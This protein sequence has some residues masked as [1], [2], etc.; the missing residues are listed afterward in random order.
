MTQDNFPFRLAFRRTNS[1]GLLEALAGIPPALG[2]VGDVVIAA[3][4]RAHFLPRPD[5][6]DWALGAEPCSADNVEELANGLAPGLVLAAWNAVN[7][8]PQVA[9]A[10]ER[11]LAAEVEK[12]QN[13]RRNPLP[14][15]PSPGRMGVGPPTGGTT[16]H[17]RTDR[18]RRA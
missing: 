7:K 3:D 5:A 12:A 15:T 16:T 1:E 9:A 14:R 11:L 13:S 17:F 18:L 10:T 4:G 2:L 6:V 8:D